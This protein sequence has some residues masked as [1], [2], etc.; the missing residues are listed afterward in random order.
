VAKDA[1]GD[2]QV[3]LERFD[4]RAF[5]VELEQVVLG[6]LVVV[7]LVGERAR[8]PRLLEEQLATRLDL[9]ASVI[10]RFRADVVGRG[11]IEH[12][13]EVVCRPGCGQDGR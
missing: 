1:V 5:A 4:Q 12:Q 10:Q 9:R 8:S 6:L 3:A 13:H 2:P 7:D 11:G